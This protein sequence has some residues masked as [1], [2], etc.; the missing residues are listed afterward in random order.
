MELK[1]LA[2]TIQMESTGLFMNRAEIDEQVAELTE[3]R[4]SSLGSFIEELDAELQSFGAEPLPRLDGGSFNLNKVTRAQ[5]GWAP[6]F[7]QV[8]TR[9]PAPAAEAFC[10]H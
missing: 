5:S 10:R 7:M 1:A 8:S 6:R 4:D 2:P 3:T 9:A